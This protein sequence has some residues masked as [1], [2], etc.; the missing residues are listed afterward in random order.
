MTCPVMYAACGCE[1]TL[2]PGLAGQ[3][4]MDVSNRMSD[5]C[6]TLPAPCVA[7]FDALVAR[8]RDHEGDPALACGIPGMM[9]VTAADPDATTPEP[10]D[11]AT[12]LGPELQ[13]LV[14]RGACERAP[15]H[16]LLAAKAM[17]DLVPTTAEPGV[18]STADVPLGRCLDAVSH[19][20]VVSPVDVLAAA[21][22]VQARIARSLLQPQDGTDP[23]VPPPCVSFRHAP[24]KKCGVFVMDFAGK[25]KLFSPFTLDITF[26]IP[27]DLSEKAA[28]IYRVQSTGK[29]NESVR[30]GMGGL[31]LLSRRES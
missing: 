6:P 31:A 10:T 28:L 11:A 15:A 21:P 12:P 14:A 18:Q 17:L 2:R 1:L 8:I 4:H 5:E 20:R 16:L 27:K 3:V 24:K 7:P 25:V 26:R 22:V 19:M 9:G 13:K 29:K 30:R 23:T